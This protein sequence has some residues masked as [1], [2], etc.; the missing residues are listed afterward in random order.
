MGANES[1][2]KLTDQNT[3]VNDYDPIP[4]RLS[5]LPGVVQY[6]SGKELASGGLVLDPIPERTP[7][8]ALVTL[9]QEVSAIEG[10]LTEEDMRSMLPR[11]ANILEDLV[12]FLQV[13]SKGI[14][15]RDI[16]D[17]KNKLVILIAKAHLV[18]LFEGETFIQEAFT[19]TQQF[20]QDYVDEL[21]SLLENPGFIKYFDERFLVEKPKVRPKSRR[22]L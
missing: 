14:V 7:I 11:L 21:R 2:E 3:S 5:E 10:V 6:V 8:A 4:D 1:K 17:L 19:F 13:N 9:E 16:N 15:F 22:W 12:F 18:K 20:F